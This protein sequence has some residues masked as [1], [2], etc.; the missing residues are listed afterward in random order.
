M[1]EISVETSF[2]AVHA[3][4]VGGVEETPHEH[5]WKVVASVQGDK[6]DDD[7]L[8]VDFLD[9]QLELEKAVSPFHNVDLNQCPVLDGQNPTAEQVA[10]YIATQLKDK[11]RAPA[12][13]SSVRVTE[14]PHCIATY[15]P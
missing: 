3:V 5:D 14:A 8:L 15:R 1:F 9:L 7:G 2:R 4:T 10:R 11:V 12:T 13:L 6:L